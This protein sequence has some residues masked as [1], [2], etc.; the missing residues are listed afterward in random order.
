MCCAKSKVLYNMA[1]DKRILVINLS[2]LIERFVS[3]ALSSLLDID[4]KTS[5]TLSNKSSAFSFRQKLDLLTDIRATDKTAVKK[6]QT[7]AEIRNQFAHNFDVHDFQSCLSFL[8]GTEN[9]LRNTYTDEGLEK[10]GNEEQL[11]SLYMHLFNDVMN[12][13]HDIL[14]KIEEKFINIGREQGSREVRDYVFNSI[15]E[16][17][18]TDP[19]FNEKYCKIIEDARA[20]FKTSEVSN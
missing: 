15:K 11:H 19:D 9:F 14:V 6:F 5:K 2:I 16:Y 10:L 4:L 20:K 18:K 12:C 8:D 1:D 7:F 17:A 13:S 3:A